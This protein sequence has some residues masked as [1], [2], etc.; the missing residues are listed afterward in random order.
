VVFRKS[1][2]VKRESSPEPDTTESEAS[3]K[4][5]TYNSV[6]ITSTTNKQLFAKSWK[7]ACVVC[8]NFKNT[9]KCMGP[10]QS[11]FHKE[12]LNKSEERYH[13]TKSTPMTKLKTKKSSGR[14]KKHNSKITHKNEGADTPQLINNI[15]E[16]N[17]AT[18]CK[19][20]DDD[21]KSNCLMTLSQT[22]CSGYTNEETISPNQL[23]SDSLFTN[24]SCIVTENENTQ[25]E[26]ESVNED[27]IQ[28]TSEEKNVDTSIVPINIDEKTPSDNLKYM[29]SLCK[30]N[31]SNCFVCGLIIDDS[32]QKI[33]CKICK[34]QYQN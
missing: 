13:K 10:C 27:S 28:G 7:R 17:T 20:E 15:K 26:L 23:E 3:S 30:A 8:K 14:R 2:T 9:V 18:L 1:T 4:N 32:G 12:C 6:F 11:Y 33:V 22:Q 16:V 5:E 29:C 25:S 31:K 21:I 24:D 19:K 34:L